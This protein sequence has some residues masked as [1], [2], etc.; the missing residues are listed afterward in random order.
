MSNYAQ[1]SELKAALRITDSVDDTQL[2]IAL[3]SASRWVDGWCDRTFAA[4]GTAITYRDFVPVDTFGIVHI[5]DC[6]QVTEV[7]IDDDLDQTY[8]KTLRAIDWAAEPVNATTY[9]LTL[10]FTRLRSYE[11]GY[12]PVWRGQPTV[13]VY[14]RYGWP[15]VPEPVKQATILQASRLFTR[16]DSPLGVA[17]MGD[18]GVMRVS[19]FV[20]PDVEQLLLPYRRVRYA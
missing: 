7:R 18:M 3:T 20:D 19:R 15:A 14:A 5:D 11:D 16:L 17:G 6:V 4:A 12:W 9:G 10:P 13:R 2:N 8:A 1:L